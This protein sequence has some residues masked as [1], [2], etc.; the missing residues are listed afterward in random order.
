M[1]QTR[2]LISGYLILGLNKKIM[3]KIA[4]TLKNGSPS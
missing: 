2:N 1:V 3:I 4:Y